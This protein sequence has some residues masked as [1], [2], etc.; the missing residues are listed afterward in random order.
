MMQNHEHE[1]PLQ[2]EHAKHEEPASDH[3]LP[4]TDDRDDQG[5]P[6]QRNPE[7][8]ACKSPPPRHHEEKHFEHQADEETN[9]E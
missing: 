3:K 1:E 6:D 4:W 8:G 9:L 2:D 7:A 5:D